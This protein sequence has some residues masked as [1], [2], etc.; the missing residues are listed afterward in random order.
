[1]LIATQEG[2]DIFDGNSFK[3]YRKGSDSGDLPAR[4]ILNVVEDKRGF[5][6]V[7]FDGGLAALNPETDRFSSYG[8]EEGLGSL[9]I[10]DISF[11]KN[12][13]MWV[14]S[15]GGV[16]RYNPESD[17][18]EAFSKKNGFNTNTILELTGDERY[19]Y[20]VG[21]DGLYVTDPDELKGKTQVANLQITNFQLSGE[22]SDSVKLMIRRN[23]FSNSLLSL[24]HTQNSFQIEFAKLSDEIAPSHM[25]SFRLLGLTTEWSTGT[26]NYASYNYLPPGEYTFEVKMAGEEQ[27]QRLELEIKPAWWQSSWFRVLLIIFAVSLL[28]LFMRQRARKNLHQR[29]LL[30]RKIKEATDEVKQQNQE[31]LNQR[32]S[33][34]D[35]ISDTN[36]VINAAVN[37]GDFTRRVDIA[38]KD[39]EWK[40]LGISIN[41][42]FEAILLPLNEVNRL[43]NKIA[44]GDFQDR[45]SETAVGYTKELADNFN[46]ALSNVV[47]LLEKIIGSVNSIQSAVHGMKSTSEVLSVNTDEIA[48]VTG[49][50]SSG[51]QKQVTEIDLSFELLESIKIA[52]V[53]NNKLARTINDDVDQSNKSSEIGITKMQSL[54]EKVLGANDSASQTSNAIDHLIEN[55]KKITDVVK[56]MK[57]VA[58]Q[59]NLLALNAAI[60]AA[61]AGEAGRGFSVVAEEIRRL[62][63]N[64]KKYA[65]DVEDL[66][67]NIQKSSKTTSGLVNG[68][69]TTLS[70]VATSTAESLSAFEAIIKSCGKALVNAQKIVVA[71]QEQTTEISRV[72][73]SVEGV[74]V[75]AEQTAS[76]TDEVASSTTLLADG[77]KEFSNQ[78]EEVSKV[79]TELLEQIKFFKTS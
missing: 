42:L 40:E 45:Y 61:Q 22:V 67:D 79:V 77:M 73:K 55:S 25:Y 31:L 52:S 63:E 21:S 11:D 64:S 23:F 75:I 57:E 71:T 68:M 29:E 78:A 50:I 20:F 7:S 76:G 34:T 30:Q 18:F 51:A 47:T 53:E 5:I 46:L 37:T 32:S 12:D 72:L 66:I 59:T 8:L 48:T 49:Q 62:A 14:S 28:I 9:I 16:A 70:S 3:H 17:R 43:V 15:H 26:A 35:A 36:T 6:W 56:I 27:V 13:L 33:L 65:T 69:N 39:G 4:N 60:E 19:L 10:T 41:S 38:N 54:N 58:S 2:L 24:A 44:E 1:M 74:T